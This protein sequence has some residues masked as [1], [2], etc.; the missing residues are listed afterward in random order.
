MGLL[1]W[2]GTFDVDGVSFGDRLLVLEIDL[3]YF[4][5]AFV[6]YLVISTFLKKKLII[7]KIYI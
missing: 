2:C 4:F 3:V 6:F 5:G 7:N 1:E